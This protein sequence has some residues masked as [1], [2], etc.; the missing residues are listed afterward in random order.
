[1]KRI[2]VAGGDGNLG[3]SIVKELQRQGQTVRIMSRKAAPQAIDSPLEWAQADILSAKGIEEALQDV[4][5]IV[6][7]ASS[8][9]QNTY[10]T[11]IV[12]TRRFLAQARQ[13]GV[14]YVLHISII[15]IDRIIYPYYQYKLAAELVV[16]ESQIPCLIARI[17]QFHSFVDYLLAPLCDIEAETIAIPVDVQFQT[18]STRDVATHLAPHI[19]SGQPVGRLPD[20]GGP[21][22][23]RLGDMA[24]AWLEVQ[25][26]K[27]T[28]RPATETKNDLPFFNAFGDGFV[29]GYNTRSDN[30][31]NG[32]TWHD[33]LQQKYG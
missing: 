26:I 14:Q 11:D 24:A 21:E 2:L 30:R 16:I 18:I 19:I 20:F 31:V 15:G 7:C 3:S 28:I 10:E 4:D 9:L 6:N 27:R 13:M 29:K 5:S 1:M 23:L 22:V 8:P 32:T 12:G 33:Y 25:G 17:A